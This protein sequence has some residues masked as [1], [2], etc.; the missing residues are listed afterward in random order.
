MDD[1]QKLARLKTLLGISDT[2]RDTLLSEYLSM[3]K[4]EIL[5]WLYSNIGS[6]PEDVTDV[7]P[8]YE[9]IQIQACI[10]GFNL[11]GAEGEILHNENG[12]QRTFHYESMVAYI[13]ANVFP[14]VGAF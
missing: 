13:H 9:Q 3:A 4:A 10:T 7:P 6:V 11:T 1:N 14:L 5:N 8:R 12:I 2:S